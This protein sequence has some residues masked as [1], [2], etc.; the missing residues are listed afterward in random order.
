ME[1]KEKKVEAAIRLAHSYLMQHDLRPRLHDGGV[2]AEPDTLPGVF[3]F[4]LFSS[5]V[6][7]Q[8]EQRRV[9]IRVATECERLETSW[10]ELQS[11]LTQWVGIVEDAQT[12]MFE[13]DTA[14]ARCQL[15]ITTLENDVDA[16]PPVEQ[17][18]LEQLTG[19][20]RVA[21][22][23]NDLLTQ[24]ENVSLSLSFS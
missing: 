2:F 24:V 12:K 10:K 8:R 11:Q 18:R 4:L 1:A 3:A 22:Q 14:L 19:A 13:L 15:A 7:E 23:A 20:Q 6:D 5:F 16:L 9:A 21:R 17:L